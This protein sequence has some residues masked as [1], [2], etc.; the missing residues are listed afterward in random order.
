MLLKFVTVLWLSKILRLEYFFADFYT[1]TNKIFI[2]IIQL[3]S[4]IILQQCCFSIY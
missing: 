1:L 3:V 4:Y 2:N